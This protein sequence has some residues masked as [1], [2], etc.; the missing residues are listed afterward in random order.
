MS[1]QTWTTYG[2]GVCISNLHITDPKRV[3]QLL[4]YAPV[5]KASILK[6]FE[7]WGVKEPTMQDYEELDFDYNLGLATVI[8]NVIE[9]AENLD[10][11]SCDDVDSNVFLIY[12]PNYPWNLTEKE[13][14]L[15]LNDIV[16]VFQ[17]YLSVLTD[18]A[19]Q[20]E[21]QEITNGG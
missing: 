10:L 13:K 20:V 17:K 8:A 9:E 21:E 5:Y 15:T 2:Y 19:I 12:E 18:D 11:T 3:G 1:Y 6:C 7:E 16:G 14:K 4:D